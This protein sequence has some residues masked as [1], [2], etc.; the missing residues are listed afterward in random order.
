MGSESE[1][2]EYYAYSSDEEGYQL[3]EEEEGDTMDWDASENPNAAPTN[4][5]K[6]TY[7]CAQETCV[8]LACPLSH[9]AFFFF[10]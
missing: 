3:E 8:T 2:Y 5:A 9:T 1:D 4:Y 10:V 7:Y 6:S